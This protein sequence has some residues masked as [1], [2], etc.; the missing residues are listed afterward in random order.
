ELL[1]QAAGWTQQQM[2]PA[3][4]TEFSVLLQVAKGPTFRIRLRAKVFALSLDLSKNRF[5]FSDT[6]VGQCQVEIVRLY[7]WFRVPCKWFITEVK[8]KVK[9]RQH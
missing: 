5:Q 4:S 3:A 8:P 1:G 9:H 6:I 2:S 7:N